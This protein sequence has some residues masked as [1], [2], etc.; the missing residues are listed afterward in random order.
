LYKSCGDPK[1]ASRF[2][3][4]LIVQLTGHALLRDRGIELIPVDAPADFTDPTPTAEM[5]RQILEA[6]SASSRRHRFTR[7][8]ELATA[9]PSVNA[10]SGGWPSCSAT[11]AAHKVSTG[12]RLTITAMQAWRQSHYLYFGVLRHLLLLHD[13]PSQSLRQHRDQ[14]AARQGAAAVPQR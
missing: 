8:A 10:V 9:R 6:R 11:T 3:R 12:A 4:D 14:D 13:R 2:A 7:A 1:N 5:V